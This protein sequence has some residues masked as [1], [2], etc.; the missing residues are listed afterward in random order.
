MDSPPPRKLSPQKAGGWGG[1]RPQK[2]GGPSKLASQSPKA[3]IVLT[4]S[5]TQ[6]K[7]QN[8]V[9]DSLTKIAAVRGLFDPRGLFFSLQDLCPSTDHPLFSEL[10]S[11]HMYRGQVRLQSDLEK[12]LLLKW[13]PRAMGPLAAG[14]DM[15]KINFRTL[16]PPPAESHTSLQQTCKFVKGTISSQAIH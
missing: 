8:S 10:F 7:S 15:C 16:D 4:I 13:Y 6:V 12:K 5:S 9:L 11:I 2:V 3:G 1:C 14:N